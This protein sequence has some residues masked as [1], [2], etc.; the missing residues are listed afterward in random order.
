MAIVAEISLPS[1]D[2]A[3]G[4]LLTNGSNMDFEFE[5]IVS[6]G[7]WTHPLFWVTDSHTDHL[8]RHLSRSDT[9][10]EFTAL[11]RVDDRV[12]YTVT[13]DC[14]TNGFLHGL[15][16][17]DAV[18]LEARCRDGDEWTMKLLFPSH[19]QL[20]AFHEF[21]LDNGIRCTPERVYPLDESHSGVDTDLLTAEQREAILLALQEGYFDSPSRITL[22]ELAD[23]MDISQ[24][25]LS[26]RIRRGTK[27]V[28]ERMLSGRRS[29]D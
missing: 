23:Q 16:S 10:A 4:R 3:L 14:P 9:V 7:I 19:A 5:R 13:W 11:G 27:A 26:Q 25:A 21:C 1:A 29:R 18:A 2:F 6:L 22:S 17:S 20:S 24:Q 15:E 28:F 12:L 8:E